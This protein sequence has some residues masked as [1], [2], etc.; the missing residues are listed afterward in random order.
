[1]LRGKIEGLHL[2]KSNF[3]NIDMQTSPT[4]T[5]QENPLLAGPAGQ[6]CPSQ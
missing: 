1:M 5:I 3:D 6:A 4:L 2:D